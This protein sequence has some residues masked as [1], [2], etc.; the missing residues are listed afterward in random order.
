M[1][2]T[3]APPA[4]RTLVLAV[5]LMAVASVFLGLAQ[6]AQGP[7]SPLR[8]YAITNVDDPV[9]LF[10]NRNHFAALLCCALVFATAWTLEVATG[11]GRAGARP[12]P[13]LLVAGIT[14]VVVLIAGVLMSRSRM[15]LLLLALTLPATAALAWRRAPGGTVARGAVFLT[16]P[17][18]VYGLLDRWSIDAL[19]ESRA[20]FAR[21]T[22]EA[23]RSHMP[24][25]TGAGT[26]T[27]IYPIFETPA[28]AL[29]DT[30]VNRTHNDFIELMLENGAPGIALMLIAAGFLATAF[31]KL[32]RQPLN[33]ESVDGLDLT[34]RRAAGFA[35]GYLM[36]HSLFDYPLRTSA[37]MAL[38]AVAAG[39]LI[40]AENKVNARVVGPSH[41]ATSARSGPTPYPSGGLLPG[42]A[43]VPSGPVDP[44]E[45]PARRGLVGVTWPASWQGN[46]TVPMRDE[47]T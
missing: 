6:M 19:Q 33:H 3:L 16:F 5:V 40:R 24:W 41:G 25:G 15:G 34:L 36:L 42:A 37:L 21:T 7:A 44:G 46:G 14:A 27:H 43:R 31:L 35:V 20:V 4:Q 23:I 11:L 26:F 29:R 38:F 17:F 22:F 13:A 18:A 30:Y 39:M 45:A 9:G 47:H 32:W 12:H 8:P 2:R 10:A 1:T 28:R